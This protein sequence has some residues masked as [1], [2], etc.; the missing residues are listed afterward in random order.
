MNL[1]KKK[2]IKGEKVKQGAKWKKE[3]EKI[4][5]LFYI[6]MYYIYFTLTFTLIHTKFSF[7]IVFAS[8][9][10]FSLTAFL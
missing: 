3:K 10:Q 9:A 7:K 1:K 8:N 6:L 4:Y 5:Y 2:K